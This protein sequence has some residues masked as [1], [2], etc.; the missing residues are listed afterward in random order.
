MEQYGMI[1]GI[2]LLAIVSVCAWMLGAKAHAEIRRFR[3]EHHRSF[4]GGRHHDAR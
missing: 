4:L 1:I 2:G 3:E